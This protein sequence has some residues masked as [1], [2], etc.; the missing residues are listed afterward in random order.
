MTT[1]GTTT[2]P[3]RPVQRLQQSA[4]AVAAPVAACLV[5]LGGLTAWTSLGHAGTPPDLRVTR[6]H[7]FQPTGEATET[8]AFFRITNQG[9][10][11]DELTEVTS[12]AVPDG[13]ALSRH[14]MTPKGAAYRAAANRLQ[15]PAQGTLDMTPRSSDVTVPADRDWRVGDRIAFD[16][17]FEHSGTVRVSA[18]V[19]RPVSL[20]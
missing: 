3:A 1:S 17:H 19:V 9:S 20:G 15:V 13:I 16:L 14:R 6:A 18:E 4:L 8:A 12:P 10:S 7:V 2:G 5:A 11:A